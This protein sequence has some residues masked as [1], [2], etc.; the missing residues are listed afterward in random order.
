M[1]NGKT[2]GGVRISFGYHNTEKD[3]AKVVDFIKKNYVFSSQYP[4]PPEPLNSTTKDGYIA[5]DNDK[6]VLSAIY[7]IPI[8]Y[9][10]AHIYSWLYMCF[11]L[12][13]ICKIINENTCIC[14]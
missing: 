5:H 11:W 7:L 4:F 14:V 6:L 10:V 2:V 1:I 12:L 13:S 8:K 3:V 9:I